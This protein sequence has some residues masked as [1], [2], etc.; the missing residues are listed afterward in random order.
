[1][2]RRRV[3]RACTPGDLGDDNRP[4]SVRTTGG[5]SHGRSGGGW[6]RVTGVLV[7]GCLGCGGRRGRV[8]PTIVYSCYIGVVDSEGP[9]A[10]GLRGPSGREEGESGSLVLWGGWPGRG[11]GS[12]DVGCREWYSRWS[13]AHR[14]YFS[15][16]W[17]PHDSLLVPSHLYSPYETALPRCPSQCGRVRGQG[18]GRWFGWIGA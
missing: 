15:S 11:R 14:A 8:T 9:G 13:R 17:Y 4:S 16:V 6:F 2:Q 12:V 5:G 7:R 3:P 18:T 1:M 10:R